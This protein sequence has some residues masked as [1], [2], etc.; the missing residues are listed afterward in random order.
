MSIF[1]FQLLTVV[2]PCV[3]FAPCRGMLLMKGIAISLKHFL[4]LLEKHG[5]EHPEERIIR[6]QLCPRQDA[7]TCSKSFFLRPSVNLRRIDRSITA[8]ET[9]VPLTCVCISHRCISQK[10]LDTLMDAKGIHA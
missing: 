7:S 8:K 10:A 6:Q 1:K 2:N 5:I 9:T 3:R 4:R